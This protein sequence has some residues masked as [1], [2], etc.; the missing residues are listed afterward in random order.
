MKFGNTTP[1]LRS[2][3][4]IKA[5]EFYLDFLEFNL[6]WEHRFEEDLPLYMQISK[7]DC[8]LHISE[9][10]GD[11]SP[12]A[13]LRIQVSNLEQYH[14]LLL[15]KNYKYARPGVQEKP[16]GS[17]DM[18]IADPFGNRLTFTSSVST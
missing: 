7:G 4:E 9:H 13:A 3:D 2:F 18:S 1:I 10:H 11:C 16:W 6:D 12:G 5:K 17:K 15:G 14:E 8:V